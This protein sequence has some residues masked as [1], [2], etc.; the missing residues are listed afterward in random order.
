VQ[1]KRGR[2]QRMGQ[3]VA[4]RKTRLENADADAMQRMCSSSGMRTCYMYLQIASSK[5]NQLTPTLPTSADPYEP[6]YVENR[7]CPN[8]DHRYRGDDLSSWKREGKGTATRQ[9]LNVIRVIPAWSAGHHNLDHTTSQYAARAEEMSFTN[10]GREREH[11][12][13]Q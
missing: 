10:M 6:I 11:L 4:R 8:L 13:H 1:T 2:P 3:G 12:V 5:R 7:K 9:E